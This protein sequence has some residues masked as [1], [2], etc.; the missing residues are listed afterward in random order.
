MDNGQ[1]TIRTLF[2]AI[3]IFNIPQYQRAYAWE[4]EELE[5][6]V[7]DIENQKLDKDY[8][9][10]T[11]LFQER[12]LQNGFEIIDIVDGQQ[13]ITTLIIFMKLLLDRISKDGYEN[14]IKMLQDIYIKSHG[15]YKLHVLDIDNDFFKSY[16]L[17]DHLSSGEIETPS[18]RRLREGKEYLYQRLKEYPLKTLQ[19]FKDKIG[20]T[21]ILTYS[22]E[23]TAEATLIFET[24]N[25]R[26]KSLTN[27]EKIKSFLMYK[28]Y[29]ASSRPKF[30]LSDLQNRFSSI[31]R[32]HEAIA[33]RGVGEDAILQYHF[34]AF[35]KWRNKREYQQHDQ[36]I[37]QQVN[38]LV[39]DGNQ[40]E[41]MDFIKRYS[42]ELKESFEFMKLL[43]LNSEPHL[44]D[45][46]ALD[47]A[48]VFYPLLIKAY[49]FDNSNEKQNFKR[50]AR[51]VEIIC[52]R[53]F[54]IR[55]RRSN[56]GREFLY[57]KV[58]DFDGNFEELINHLKNIIDWHC[59]NR[60][61]HDWLL[62]RNFYKEVKGNDQRY[63]FWKYENHL[64]TKKQPIF[65]EM[66]YSEFANRDS[67]TNFSIEHII[68]QNPKESK[69]TAEDFGSILP[70][71]TQEFE[72][73]Y[74]HG[75]GNL[76]IDPKSANSSKSN[77]P[78]KEKDQ[79]YFRKAPLKTQNELSDFLNLETGRWDEDSIQRRMSKIVT[80]ALN[81]WNHED[82]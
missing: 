5:A 44:L 2:N 79:K 46:F 67:R 64:R 6:F 60:D 22:V 28:T 49:K 20:R 65:P 50:V 33:D 82:V 23:D 74:L 25:D 9:F 31:Y 48:A 59:S 30:H 11:I 29:L 72:E 54:G 12:G 14:E 17:E 68:P 32:N 55:K 47:R 8:F 43:L 78:F 66:S 24:T 70:A 73:N 15:E 40:S 26:G 51:L 38:H 3:R 21:K 4:K 77:K 76:T 10:G 7:D 35:E 61:F 37:K 69:V 57:R 42:R 63:L 16:I 75:I 56:T 81:Y 71:M 34:I 80:F 52:F 39:N 58:R 36:M 41:A 13:R 19:E 18:Q 27:L 45:I 62:V 1:T 53:V